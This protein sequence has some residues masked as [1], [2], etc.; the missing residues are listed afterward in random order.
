[1]SFD[2]KDINKT[3][4][5]L[6]RKLIGEELLTAKSYLKKHLE[7]IDYNRLHAAFW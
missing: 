4:P 1:M 3:T 7:E 5:N 2:E 6:I